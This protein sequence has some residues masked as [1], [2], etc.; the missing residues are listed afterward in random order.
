[1]YSILADAKIGERITFAGYE[2]DPDKE[3]KKKVLD[4]VFADLQ[5][6]AEGIAVYKGTVPFMTSKGPCRVKSLVNA[7]LS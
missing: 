4:Q 2:G 7:K 6:N 1:L 5:T 3:V